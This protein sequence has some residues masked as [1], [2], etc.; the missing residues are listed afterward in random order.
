MQRALFEKLCCDSLRD[1]ECLHKIVEIEP[2]GFRFKGPPLD[3]TCGDE[4]YCDVR[5]RRSLQ[6]RKAVRD[7]P[8]DFKRA[9]LLIQVG[10]NLRTSDPQIVTWLRYLER[11]SERALK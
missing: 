7:V 6:H 9:L 10:V 1:T 2:F 5:R 3:P 4:N 8:A 11:N